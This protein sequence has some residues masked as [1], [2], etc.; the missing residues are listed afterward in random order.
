MPLRRIPQTAPALA[1]VPKCTTSSPASSH[2]RQ[3]HTNFQIL[4]FRSY[5]SYVLL[6]LMGC[7][8][9]VSNASS[10]IQRLEERLLAPGF[11]FRVNKA[12]L[13]Q[14]KT[15]DTGSETAK[16]L[17]GHL[18]KLKHLWN[19]EREQE[20]SH[21]RCEESKMNITCWKSR[22]TGVLKRAKWVARTLSWLSLNSLWTVFLILSPLLGCGH[23]Q[24]GWQ[25]IT[26]VIMLNYPEVWRDS[27]DVIKFL[28][29]DSMFFKEE[30]P[31][32]AWPDLCVLFIWDSVYCCPH[33]LRIYYVPQASHGPG[34]ACSLS[35]PR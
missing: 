30:Y 19:G 18:G 3:S 35:P 29:G 12:V 2:F 28:L 8:T 1:P 10:F 34:W 6:S 5:N 24:W 16:Y 27:A 14:Y 9:S 32:W 15:T 23:D 13:S 22:D 21:G 4:G 17:M 11:I 26:T 31:E 33:W 7:F 20:R 25:L